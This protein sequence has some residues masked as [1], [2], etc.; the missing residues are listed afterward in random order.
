[1][2]KNW[3]ELGQCRY[4]SKCQ[5]AHGNVELI[6]K[7]PTNNKYKSKMCKQFHERFFCPYGKRCL[8]KHE[9]RQI[10][11]LANYNYVY[12]LIAL[13]ESSQSYLSCAAKC[14]KS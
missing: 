6:S 9:D 8:F 12:S 4:G 2:C 1:M 7:E 10:N 3:I 11:E 5:F 14:A 13:E